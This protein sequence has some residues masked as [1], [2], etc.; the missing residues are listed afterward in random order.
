MSKWSRFCKKALEIELIVGA[1]IAILASCAAL[2]PGA[3]ILCGVE[4]VKDRM[5]QYKGVE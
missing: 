3:I 1:V 2:I 4:F 5:Y